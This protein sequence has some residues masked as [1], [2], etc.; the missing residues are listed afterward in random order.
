MTKINELNEGLSSIQSS[1]SRGSN[2]ADV[3]LQIRKLDMLSK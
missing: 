1:Y 2:M 3:N